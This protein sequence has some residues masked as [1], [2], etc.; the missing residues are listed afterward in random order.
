MLRQSNRHK[1]QVF[2]GPVL[3]AAAVQ[4]HAGGLRCAPLCSH[5]LPLLQRGH[6]IRDPA[7]GPARQ[8]LGHRPRLQS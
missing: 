7:L 8:A 2:P 5:Q 3:H 6:L 4:L 1:L